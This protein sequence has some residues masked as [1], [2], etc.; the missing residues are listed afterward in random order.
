MRSFRYIAQNEKGKRISGRMD[1]ADELDLAARLKQ[2][3]LMLISFQS[4]SGEARMKALSDQELSD[5]FRQLSELTGAGITLVRALYIIMQEDELKSHLKRAYDGLVRSIRQGNAVSDAMEQQG[6]FPALAVNMLRAAEASGTL[7]QTAVRLSVY[8]GKQYKLKSRLKTAT[9]YT[10]VLC[11]VIIA[12]VAFIMAFVMPQFAD[13]F[14]QLESLPAPTRFLMWLS[15]TIVTKWPV[16]IVFAVMLLMAGILVM[17]I[18]WVRLQWDKLLLR[19]PLLGKQKQIICTAQFART[20]SSLYSSGLPII[21]ALNLAGKTI[22]N[23]YIESQFDRVLA[24]VRGGES[25]SDALDQVDGFAKKLISSIRVG[26]ESGSL[27]SMLL[28]IAD[29]LDY[30]SEQA[31]NRLLGYLEPLLIIVMAGIVGFI[32]L[33]VIVPIYESYSVLEAGAYQGY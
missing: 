32:M 4:R 30:D 29:A 24:D 18:G 5:F 9:L 7:D 10:K 25:L 19:M 6:V 12:A 21:A 16:I 22:G 2:N 23:G 17:R 31:M 26:E 3:G 27:D 14:S 33:A 8:Y 15:D 13:M 28:S 20:L 1:A 11:I